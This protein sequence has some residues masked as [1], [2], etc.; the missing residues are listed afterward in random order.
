MNTKPFPVPLARA[1]VSLMP[2]TALARIVEGVVRQMERRHPKL[3]K[4]LAELP[5]AIVH[6]CPTDLPHAFV[7]KTGQQP[8]FFGVLDD[9]SAKIP[10]ARVAGT[11]EA[12]IDMLEGRADGDTL[13]F[14]RDIQVTG[15]TA[16]IV[17]LRNTLDREEIAL[18]DEILALCGPFEKP[19]GLALDIG[20]RVAGKVR[21]HLKDRLARLH[22]EM[23]KNQPQKENTP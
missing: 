15:D 7:L 14:S 8:V 19:V 13:F 3:F 1:V 2:P 21:A 5:T 18:Y 23:H 4:N 11:L 22:E 16:V 17:G 6:L 9:Q 12:L 10:N 20:G